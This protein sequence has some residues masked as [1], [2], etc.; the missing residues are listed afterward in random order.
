MSPDCGCCRRQ[1]TIGDRV[2]HSVTR[3]VVLLREGGTRARRAYRM[4]RFWDMRLSVDTLLGHDRRPPALHIAKGQFADKRTHYT[5]QKG[6]FSD[7]VAI[8]Y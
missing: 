6:R 1:T 8:L 5:L 4:V 7:I 3:K 2:E